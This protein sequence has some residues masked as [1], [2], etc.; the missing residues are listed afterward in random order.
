MRIAA[1]N[2]VCPRRTGTGTGL[3]SR[4]TGNVAVA[5]VHPAFALTLRAKNPSPVRAG[6][7]IETAVVERRVIN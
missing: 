5:I 6:H 4:G 7:H 3:V 1:K 2:I